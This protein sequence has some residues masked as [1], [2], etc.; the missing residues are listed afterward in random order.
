[1]E[2]KKREDEQQMMTVVDHDSDY[3]K[4]DLNE[5]KEMMAYED[6]KKD[7]KISSEDKK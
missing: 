3:D 7:K 6:D 2:K 1:M 5:V 4:Y